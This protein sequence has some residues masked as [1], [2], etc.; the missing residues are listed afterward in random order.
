MW[1]LVSWLVACWVALALLSATVG[2]AKRPCR[3]IYADRQV[4][5]AGTVFAQY[6]DYLDANG[7]DITAQ[8]YVDMEEPCD[9]PYYDMYTYDV[10]EYD[11]TYFAQPYD[12]SIDVYPD[13]Q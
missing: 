11:D 5:A 6:D 1:K 4:A 12:Y 13:Y 10:Y 3:T 2:L 8:D 9:E 7:N